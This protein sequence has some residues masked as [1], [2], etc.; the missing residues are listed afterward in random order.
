MGKSARI[1]QRPGMV[2]N[3][4]T[5]SAQPLHILLFLLP[6]VVAYEIRLAGYLSSG[7]GIPGTI[8][9]HSDITRLFEGVFS[10]SPDLWLSLGGAAI[11]ITLFAKHLLKGDRWRISIPVPL[12]ML[13][14][15]LFWSLPLLMLWQIMPETVVAAPSGGIPSQEEMALGTK[16]FISIGAGL[17]EEFLFR[18][19]TIAAVHAFLRDLLRMRRLHAAAL[20]IILAAILFTIYH[21][22][23]DPDGDFNLRLVLFYFLAGIYLGILYLN[24]EFGIVV[25]THMLYDAIIF[26]VPAEHA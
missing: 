26:L 16:L 12:G 13:C 10:L 19:I 15:S 21:P 8:K 18:W 23:R 6:F 17:Y 22:I 1:R 9:A 24:R 5:L 7:D 3:Y 2:Q 4:L 14:E 11:L 25:G 20:S